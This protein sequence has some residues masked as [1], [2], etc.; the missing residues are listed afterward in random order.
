MRRN[1]SAAS[2]WLKVKV[3]QLY[4][5]VR[6]MSLIFSRLYDGLYGDTKYTIALTLYEQPWIARSI[7]RGPARLDEGRAAIG[8]RAQE[9]G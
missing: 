9:S 3:T 8:V 1:N 2:L 7:L 5:Q 6:L 4:E